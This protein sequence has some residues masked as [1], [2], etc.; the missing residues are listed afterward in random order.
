MTSST[1]NQPSPTEVSSLSLAEPAVIRAIELV[2][3]EAA[4]LDSKDYLAWQN[5]Y[6][7]DA[8]YVVPVERDA[9][10]FEDVLNMVY[11]DKRMRELR[12]QRMTEG[13][14][15]AAVDAATTVRTV[16]RFA[17]QAHGDGHVALRAAQ[18]LIAYKRG[19]YDIWAGDVDYVIRFGDSPEDDQIVRKVVRLI[20]TAEAVPA[21]GFLL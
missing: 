2:W 21:A 7:D 18:V 14:A 13:Y 9:T 19:S 16:S 12:V 5:L 15:I 1:Q 11:D 3:R 6:A 20:D 4:L 10:E 8:V 17:A